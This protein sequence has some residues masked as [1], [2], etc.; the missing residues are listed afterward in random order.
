MDN[1]RELFDDNAEDHEL[2][3]EEMR[4]MLE[5]R[6]Q[7]LEQLEQQRALQAQLEQL[8]MLRA[9]MENASQDVQAST[10]EDDSNGSGTDGEDQP[11]LESKAE[12]KS[13]LS[14]NAAPRRRR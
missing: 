6:Q 13:F 2:S 10:E 12:C 5:Y 4:Q 1:H 3:E 11:E 7:L 14:E 9:Q 8:Q